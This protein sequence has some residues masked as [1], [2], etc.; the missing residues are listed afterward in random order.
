ML[1]RE[2]MQDHL[3]LLAVQVGQAIQEILAIL[4][5]MDLAELVVIREMVDTLVMVQIAVLVV[6]VVIRELVVATPGDLTSMDQG[7]VVPVVLEVQQMR[8]MVLGRMVV[9]VVLV[10]TLDIVLGLEDMVVEVDMV[11]GVVAAEA[12]AAAVEAVVPMMEHLVVLEIPV[13]MV[14]VPMMAKM[15]VLEHL[16]EIVGRVILAI[17]E[18]LVVQI[19]QKMANQLQLV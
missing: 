11:D 16:L 15:E 19:L 5:I 3:V 1:V 7:V 14:M 9:M 17:R 10:E 4:V 6:L 18:T 8:F 2:E 13:A 12:A